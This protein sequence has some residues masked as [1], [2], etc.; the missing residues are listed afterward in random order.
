MKFQFNKDSTVV[1]P[2]VPTSLYNVESACKRNLVLSVGRVDPEK[3]FDLIGSIGTK[4]PEAKFVLVGGAGPTG[5]R[6][7]EGIRER[8]RRA[9]LADNFAY[10]GRVAEPEKRELLLKAKVLLHP[11]PYESFSITIVEAM[12]AGA[13]PIAHNS[14]GTPEVVKEDNLFTTSE[15]AVE[16]IKNALSIGSDAAKENRDIASR[17]SEERFEKELLAVVDQRLS[18][19]STSGDSGESRGRA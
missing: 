6:I 4:I 14:G 1:Y 16:R 17:F 12:A 18:H 7:V 9:G 10:L 11:A 2:P 15:E 3:R 8:F 19:H 13:I 5:R